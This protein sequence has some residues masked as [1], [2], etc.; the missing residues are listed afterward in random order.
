[1]SSIKVSVGTRGVMEGSVNVMGRKGENASLEELTRELRPA[2]ID[3]LKLWMEFIT[4]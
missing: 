2:A 1:M 3:M 4:R